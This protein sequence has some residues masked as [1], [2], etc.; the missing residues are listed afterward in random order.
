[1]KVLMKWKALKET[2]ATHIMLTGLCAMQ[3]Q[4]GKTELIV[5]PSGPLHDSSNWGENEEPQVACLE[6][7]STGHAVTS[8]R[9]FTSTRHAVM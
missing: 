7:Q 1:M 2:L 3:V 9:I 5:A 8:D 6:G 4:C